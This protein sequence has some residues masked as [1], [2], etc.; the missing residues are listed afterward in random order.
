MGGEETKGPA[1]STGCRNSW[2]SIHQESR[3]I[4][5]EQAIGSAKGLE[6]K[7]K[8][9]VRKFVRFDRVCELQ[10]D[11]LLQEDPGVLLS[12]LT[13][14]CQPSQPNPPATARR[15]SLCHPQFPILLPTVASHIIIPTPPSEP[16]RFPPGHL[17]S[18]AT[19]GRKWHRPAF[20]ITIC[21]TYSDD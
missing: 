11:N 12:F 21:G 5:E 15:V 18:Q 1:L 19:A 14:T 16:Q 8:R 4:R 10:D 17:A 20:D 7:W 2:I 3:E 6:D 9:S 13:W